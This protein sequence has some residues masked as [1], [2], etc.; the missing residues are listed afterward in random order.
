[1]PHGGRWARQV[2]IYCWHHFRSVVVLLALSLPYANCTR[3][4]ELVL[5][6]VLVLRRCPMRHLFWQAS[7]R[8][9]CTDERFNL[10]YNKHINILLSLVSEQVS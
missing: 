9:T 7:P 4:S 5:V 10:A 3:L 1:M 6:L 8:S 2:T